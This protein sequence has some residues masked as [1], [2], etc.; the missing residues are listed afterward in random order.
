MNRKELKRKLNNG[1][2]QLSKDIEL[3]PINFESIKPPADYEMEEVYETEKSFD[4]KNSNTRRVFFHYRTVA[5]VMSLFLL[6]TLAFAYMKE[7][8]EYTK[9]TIRVNASTTLYIKDSKV[10]KIKEKKREGKRIIAGVKKNDSVE[11]AIDK[12]ICNLD[13]D[14]CFNQDAAEIDIQIKGQEEKVLKAKTSDQL[15]ITLSN[16]HI[17]VPVIINDEMMK[18][19]NKD[20]AQDE[21]ESQEDDSDLKLAGK[22]QDHSSEETSQKGKN[23]KAND[24]E[25]NDKAGDRKEDD[26]ANDPTTKDRNNDKETNQ[27]E[28][29]NNQAVKDEDHDDAES[30]TDSDSSRNTKENSNSI[31][32]QSKQ[33]EEKNEKEIND[34]EKTVSDKK[35][36]ES[37][38]ITESTT[39]EDKSTKKETSKEKKR[40]KRATKRRKEKRKNKK[41]KKNKKNKKNKESGTD[42]SISSK[43]EQEVVF[44]SKS[45]KDKLSRQS[46]SNKTKEEESGEKNKTIHTDAVEETSES[47]DKETEK[48][49]TEVN[50]SKKDTKKEE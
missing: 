37:T 48:E 44:R 1:F 6:I 50:T 21:S 40:K 36:S 17:S 45:E 27:E 31:K 15:Q 25:I 10:V 49:I 8:E 19:N 3:K 12:I 43:D 42:S 46:V 29:S 9:L 4:T 41:R 26:K 23:D 22:K 39:E 32:D 11:E 5:V 34:S 13:D 38:S 24:E 35:S 18:R 2:D 14:G 47:I 7:Q 33:T 16:H 28:T 30:D 20:T